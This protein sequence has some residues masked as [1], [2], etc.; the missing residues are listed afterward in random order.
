MGYVKT[1]IISKAEIFFLSLSLERVTKALKA[2]V[3]SVDF[4]TD[5]TEAAQHGFKKS[6]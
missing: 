6:Y 5:Q 2:T 3:S 1:E 4:T